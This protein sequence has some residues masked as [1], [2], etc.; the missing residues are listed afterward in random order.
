MDLNSLAQE[1]FRNGWQD[2]RPGVHMGFNF[3][4]VG[5]RRPMLGTRWDILVKVLPVLDMPM[6]TAWQ[7]NFAVIN[8]QSKSI[9]WGRCFLL[10]LLAQ[11]VSPEAL[12]MLQGDSFGLFGVLR[13]EGGGG[14]IIVADLKNR[15]VYGKIPALPLDVHNMTEKTLQLLWRVLNAGGP[16]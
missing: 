4:L 1:L 15:Q 13:W 6:A 12:P 3:D 9:W 10:C 5:N 14:N 16:A 7:Q 8:S 11:E 2:V